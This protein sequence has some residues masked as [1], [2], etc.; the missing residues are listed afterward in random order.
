MTEATIV[1]KL[2]QHGRRHM[3]KSLKVKE[4]TGDKDCDRLVNDITNYPHAF[5]I[6]CVM[7]RQIK[8]ELAWAIPYKLKERIGS[9]DFP[10]LYQLKKHDVS[11]YLNKPSPLHRHPNKMSECL[12]KTIQIIGNKYEGDA[13]RIWSD[14]P[15]SAEV[16]YRFLQIHGVGPKIATMA[17]NI[18]V[19]DFKIEFKDYDSIDLSVDVHVKRV[20]QR[21]GLTEKE[22]STIEIID[23]ARELY[24]KFPGIMDFPCWEIGRKWCRTRKTECNKCYMIDVCPS[25]GKLYTGN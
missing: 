7:D 16:V 4:F 15:S 1:N 12:Y 24:P 9:F 19:R 20:F 5:V 17:A 18:L 3:Q 6:A 22:Q 13:S 21:L 11:N 2:V 8:A 14:N 23:R 10:T 25:S